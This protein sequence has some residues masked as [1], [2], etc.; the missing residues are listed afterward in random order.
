MHHLIIVW[1]IYM[2]ISAILGIC[3]QTI[4]GIDVIYIVI[5][6]ICLWFFQVCFEYLIWK[7][8]KKST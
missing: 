6:L 7:L 5:A 8:F 2:F 4:F 1:I 3:C